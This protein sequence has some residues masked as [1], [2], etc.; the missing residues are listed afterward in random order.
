M[1][2]RLGRG[3]RG[4]AP[5]GEDPPRPVLMAPVERC[6]PA[7]LLHRRPALRQP[8]FRPAIAALGDEFEIVAATDR[9]RG[10]AELIEPDLVA[11][12]LVVECESRT[13]MADLVEPAGELDPSGR[14]RAP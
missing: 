10:E 11:R 4:F 1:A 12:P 5:Q 13:A 2:D 14:P 7:L 3:D 6:L 8:E 9:V